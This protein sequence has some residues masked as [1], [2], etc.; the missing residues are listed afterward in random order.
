ML[1]ATGFLAAC[2]TPAAEPDL[3]IDAEVEA[4]VREGRDRGYPSLADIP[5]R[6]ATTA[7][8][9]ALASDADALAAEASALRSLREAAT[10]RQPDRTLTAEAARLRAAVARDR[11]ELAAQ[12]PIERPA[13]PE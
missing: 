11:A 8:V 2:A 13:P 1:V 3:P 9:A 4:A 10:T 7:D 5:K 12:P 6:Q